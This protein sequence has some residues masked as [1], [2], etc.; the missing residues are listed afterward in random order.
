MRK[1][2]ILLVAMALALPYVVDA[3]DY[4]TK[5]DR[6]TVR[7]TKPI[8]IPT[9]TETTA[10]FVDLTEQGVQSGLDNMQLHGRIEY[11]EA[12]LPD[13][14]QR[15]Y[16]NWH[17]ASSTTVNNVK[18]PLEQPLRSQFS[19]LDQR[20]NVGETM[21]AV[22]DLDQLAKNLQKLDTAVQE[23]EAA[24]KETEKEK[25]STVAGLTPSSSSPATATSTPPSNL[26]VNADVQTTTYEECDPFIDEGGRTVYKRRKTI[27]TGESGKIYSTSM[28]ENYAVLGEIKTKQGDCTYVFDMA[29]NN[30]TATEQW[31]Y[32]DTST[33]DEVNVGGCRDSDNV[34][35]ISNRCDVALCPD[36]FDEPN[37]LVF[38]QCSKGIMVGETWFPA[39]SGCQPQD[40]V[41]YAVEWEYVRDDNA[42]IVTQD[43]FTNGVSYPKIRKFYEHPEKGKTYLT[44][45]VASATESYPH[46]HE[47]AAC[48]WIMND[49]ELKA[50]QL[51]NTYIETSEGVKELQECAPRTAP[52]PYAFLQLAANATIF[53]F[54]AEEGSFE[55]PWV[56]SFVGP[57]GI[58]NI[59]ATVVA[60]GKKGAPGVVIGNT[61][62]NLGAGGQGGAAGQ[63]ITN[64]PV[65]ITENEVV[66]LYVGNSTQSQF[67]NET[68]SFEPLLAVFNDYF[69]GSPF[70]ATGGLGGP[71][72]TPS[73]VEF[74]NGGNGD[75]F[76]YQNVFKAAGGQGGLGFGGG[77]GGG[78][79]S[80][81]PNNASYTTPRGGGGGAPGVIIITFKMKEYLR[82]DGSTFKTPYNG[83]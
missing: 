37:N 72:Y 43:D 4:V 5:Q 67:G 40:G 77:G 46:L 12:K 1:F 26:S 33:G 28:C 52:V 83:D 68:S 20:V 11:D 57:P 73:F 64:S 9:D 25:T 69:F 36:Y 19:T 23:K 27:V 78:A 66:P 39:P 54:H 31:Y 38:P 21:T 44:E 58:T 41:S 48:G 80:W 56:Q 14:S 16:V 47:T 18:Q 79:G 34:F 75:S 7:I 74:P 76:S 53:T 62:S 60:A 22:G 45:A 2:L 42:T 49:E 10:E 55:D 29:A 51:S 65:T 6:V 24:V 13:G 70:G 71:G 50:Q 81:S 35:P 8:T 15:A 82:P 63:Q 59:K 32:V 3:Q 30:A 17:S 61:F